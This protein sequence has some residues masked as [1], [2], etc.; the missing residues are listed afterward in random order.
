[1]KKLA[2]VPLAFVGM[3]FGLAVPLR[4]Q[5]QQAKKIG[6][7]D[8]FENLWSE[9]NAN[10]S[11]F[12]LKGVSWPESYRKYRPRVNEQLT[13]DQLFTVCWEMLEELKDAHVTLT[14]E[15]TNMSR[16]GGKPVRL[17]EDFPNQKAL[18]SL[19]NVID[20]NLK[21][22]GFGEMTRVKF[23]IPYLAG[24]VIEFSSNSLF[25]YLRINLMFGL[26]E[27]KFNQAIVE[28]IERF[29]DLAGVIVD[30]RFNTGGL[31]TYSYA[32]AGRFADIKR[33]GHYRRL[34]SKDGFS[35]LESWV[36][37][38]SGKRQFVKPVVLLTSSL[39]VSAGDVFAMAM[40]QLPH[41][42]IIG[43]NTQGFFSDTYDGK[44]PNGW[45]FTLSFQQYFTVDKKN[46]E[47]IGIAPDILVINTGKDLKESKDPLLEKALEILNG[48]L[49]SK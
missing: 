1:M 20:G 36:V 27:D 47:G 43:E 14:D 42:T 35:E 3:V 39:V 4:L 31:D 33:L 26:E 22:D 46:P 24:H 48:K 45:T 6:P 34:K 44:L 19:L 25:G 7:V 40:K 12:E 38:P 10:Y 30:V 41:V 18:V 15:A 8:V 17:L 9:F 5:A 29:K 21:Q 13:G 2:W 37:Q 32:I 49:K 16:H 23:E 11:F 28:A